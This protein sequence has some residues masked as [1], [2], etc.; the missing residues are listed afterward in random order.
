MLDCENG[1]QEKKQKSG[2]V[3]TNLVET[4][5]FETNLQPKSKDHKRHL[6]EKNSEEIDGEEKEC[7]SSN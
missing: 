1:Y 2:E 5:L 7:G 6:K 4:I 3:E